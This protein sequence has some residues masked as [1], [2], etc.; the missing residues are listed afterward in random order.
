MTFSWNKKEKKE[1]KEQKENKREKTGD[2]HLFFSFLVNGLS[3][4]VK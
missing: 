3:S 4:S 1:Q 2:F